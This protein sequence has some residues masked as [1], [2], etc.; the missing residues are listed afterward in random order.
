MIE[1]IVLA[2]TGPIYA[3]LNPRDQSFAQAQ[4]EL[5]ALE[6]GG[7]EVAIIHPTILE[8]YTLILRNLRPIAAYRWLDD[9]TAG[10]VILPVETSDYQQAFAT[11]S[12]YSDQD[13]T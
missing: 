8:A 11:V 5:G 12:R 1:R 13:V 4:A 7:F 10:A 3:A 2:D 6:D 9:I